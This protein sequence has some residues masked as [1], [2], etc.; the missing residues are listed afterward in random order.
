MCFEWLRWQWF[1]AIGLRK[2]LQ[3]FLPVIPILMDPKVFWCLFV[4]MFCWQNVR[5]S[6][7]MDEMESELFYNPGAIS[8]YIDSGQSIATY[9]SRFATPNGGEMQGFFF[10]N[11]INLGLG[12]I[13]ICPGNWYSIFLHI[14]DI[15][16]IIYI[17]VIWYSIICHIL[18]IV[19]CPDWNSTRYSE[20]SWNTTFHPGNWP[21]DFVTPWPAGDS[22]RQ[23]LSFGNVDQSYD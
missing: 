6:R 8:F 2:T 19:I 15:P 11:A 13:V 9:S 22:P 12:I 17:P 7:W 18:S 20:Y 10:P 14:I 1:T 21:T 16:Y 23:S 4:K 5:E 3:N